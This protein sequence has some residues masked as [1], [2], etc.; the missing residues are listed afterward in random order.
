MCKGAPGP[1]LKVLERYTFC[2]PITSTALLLPGVCWASAAAPVRC[3]SSLRTYAQSTNCGWAEC[4]VCSKQE[5]T[6]EARDCGVLS[7]CWQIVTALQL[8]LS[9]AYE[10]NIGWQSSVHKH[11]VGR[12]CVMG[13][14]ALLSSLPVCRYVRLELWCKLL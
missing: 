5:H 6:C 2:K 3:C 8:E 7:C 9:S 12:K 4:N 1:N 13:F 14:P 11:L 10:H